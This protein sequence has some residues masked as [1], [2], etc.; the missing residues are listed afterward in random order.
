MVEGDKMK[1]SS[2]YLMVI[3]CGPA[4]FG[5]VSYASE[6]D[7]LGA[8]NPFLEE[9]KHKNKHIEPNGVVIYSFAKN[10]N[11]I[12]EKSSPKVLNR[13]KILVKSAMLS[14]GREELQLVKISNPL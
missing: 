11:K 10:A 2:L 3:F 4:L 1:K 13:L 7:E 12:H 6:F 8:R 9:K 14:N 5:K